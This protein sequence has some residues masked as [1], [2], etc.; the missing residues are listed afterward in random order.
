MRPR[1]SASSWVIPMMTTGRARVSVTTGWDKN[2]I[3]T[4]LDDPQ[5]E[6][7]TGVPVGRVIACK[8]AGLKDRY[9]RSP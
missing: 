2:G 4:D 9:G 8:N 6:R 1:K 3:R 5:A 7:V